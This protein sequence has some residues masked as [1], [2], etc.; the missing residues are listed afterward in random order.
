MKLHDKEYDLFP[1]LWSLLIKAYSSLGKSVMTPP[2][3]DFSGMEKEKIEKWLQK[4]NFTENE[5]IYFK[6]C[7]DKSLTLNKI[8]ETRDIN[9]ATDHLTNFST[10]FRRN[11]IFLNPAVR[12]KFKQIDDALT[13][14]WFKKF[15]RL[16]P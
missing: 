10:S 4:N 2:P 15:R 16:S 13:N 11:S 5:K 8:I 3:F 12:A 7:D 14:S 6:K 9:D 1:E